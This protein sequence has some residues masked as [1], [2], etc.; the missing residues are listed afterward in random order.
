MINKEYIAGQEHDAYMEDF[1]GIVLGAVKKVIG[2]A[3]KYNVDRDNAMEHFATVF[4]TMQEV[5][6]FQNRSEE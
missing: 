2:L 3:D 1:S 5:S 6:T 4:K